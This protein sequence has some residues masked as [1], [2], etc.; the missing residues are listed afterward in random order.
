M[1]GVWG[2]A[3]EDVLGSSGSRRLWELELEI[4][5]AGE[6]FP[7]VAQWVKNPTSIHEDEGSVPGLWHCYKPWHS[8]QMWL[9]YG[10]TVAV[11]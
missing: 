8:L 7:I 6:G 10:V 2:S 3:Q 1:L 5:R 4:R 9:G 11:V